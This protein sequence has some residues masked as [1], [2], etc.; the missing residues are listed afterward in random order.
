MQPISPHQTHSLGL[1]VDTNTQTHR[2]NEGAKQTHTGQIKQVEGKI[3]RGKQLRQLRK[4]ARFSSHHSSENECR[5]VKVQ[6]S[7]EN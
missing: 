7:C 3:T 2:L 4:Q 6:L 5:E 1:S